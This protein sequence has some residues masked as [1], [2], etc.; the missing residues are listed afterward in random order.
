M[1]SWSGT[2]EV[3]NAYGITETGSWLAGTTVSGFT[4]EDGL[5][6]EA[7]GGVIRVLKRADP[8][9]VTDPG[10]MCR[11]GES[12]YVWRSTRRHSCAV[13]SI[14]TISPRTS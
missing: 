14:V 13:T 11:A 1:R 2:E 6:G 5:I 7:W 4:P 12:G 3:L 10:S 9:A 8:G